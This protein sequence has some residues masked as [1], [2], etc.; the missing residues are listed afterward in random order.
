MSLE[1]LCVYETLLSH[2]LSLNYKL[3]YLQIPVKA[4]FC[5][6][7]RPKAWYSSEVVDN[8]C[9]NHLKTNFFQKRKGQIVLESLQRLLMMFK[10]LLNLKGKMHET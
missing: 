1:E 6:L 5:T 4:R 7:S 3:N 9:S 10:A 2:F 8:F